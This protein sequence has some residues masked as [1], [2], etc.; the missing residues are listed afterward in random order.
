MAGK[1]FRFSLQS[2][3]DLRRREV[4]E[5]EHALGRAVQERR[6]REEHLA[7]TRRKRAEAHAAMP[8]G[9]IDPTV[10]RRRAGFLGDL[11]SAEAEAARRLDVVREQET[12]ARCAL[13][14]RRQPEEALRVLRDQEASAHRRAQ[15]KAEADFLDE[16][17]ST[18]HRR[19][20]RPVPHS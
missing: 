19:R 13:T 6:E 3:L 1:T 8:D 5:A 10:L 20:I 12:E 15:A 9:P 14:A 2:V 7:A 18:R 11:R 4:E 17:A 16:Q